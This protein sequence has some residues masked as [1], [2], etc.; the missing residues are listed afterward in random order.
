[1]SR[2][3]VCFLALAAAV[4]GIAAVRFSSAAAAP[5]RAENEIRKVLEEQT[6]AW[7]RGDVEGFMRGY[8][9]SEQ[10]TFAGVNGIT[11][12]WLGVLERYR[13]SYPDRKAMG[14]LTFSELEITLLSP[15]AALVLGRWQLQRE[16]DQP[17]G[18]FTLV[19]RKMPEG[20]RIVHDHTSSVVPPK[21]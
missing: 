17:G 2:K 19:L 1:M 11:R 10:L 15:K 13:R 7:N 6:V 9:R 14:R 8:W 21:Q 20:W 12:G 5:D 4:L 18:V 3:A 16:G